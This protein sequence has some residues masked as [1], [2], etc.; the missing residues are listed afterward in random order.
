MTKQNSEQGPNKPEEKPIPLKALQQDLVQKPK[1]SYGQ[2]LEDTEKAAGSLLFIL[3]LVVLI[4]GGVLNIAGEKSTE[5]FV[6][7]IFPFLISA[8]GFFLTWA[9]FFI[10]IRREKSS[11]SKE[12]LVE[13][14]CLV[15]KD[16]E[17]IYQLKVENI[18]VGTALE[19]AVTFEDPE[20]EAQPTKVVKSV[21]GAGRKFEIPLDKARYNRVLI[22]FK[23][24]DGESLQP[25]T[26]FP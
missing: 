24:I 25:I 21:V 4:L 15:T 11:H 7:G 22:S 14:D 8:V 23:N 19:V 3:T 2:F 17:G 1:R 12:L 5:L 13:L 26:L 6:K 20:S 9:S 16:K 18:G 10:I